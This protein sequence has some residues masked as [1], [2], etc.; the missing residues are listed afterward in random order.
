MRTQVLR[1]GPH[2]GGISRWRGGA[3]TVDDARMKTVIVPVD[4]SD[5]SG[6]LVSEAEAEAG[7][8]GAALR[9]L[10]VIEPTA[11]VAGFE[12][13]PEMMR[14]RVGQDLDAAQRIEHTRLEEMAQAVRA[15]G[16]E[17]SVAVRFGLPSDEILEEVKDS[18]AELVVM[19]SHGHGALFHLFAGSVVTGVLKHTVCP[20][21]VVPLRRA[22][23]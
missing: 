4:F 23:K 17:C 18:G 13:D 9:L 1:P 11:E 22:G 14:L 7:R 8:R 19:G 3:G 20:V 10:H 6:K 12:T 15:R 16:A 21:L 5:A 2:K